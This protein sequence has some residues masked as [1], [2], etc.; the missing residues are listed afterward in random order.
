MK[1][2]FI[3]TVLALLSL[4]TSGQ[5]FFS[6][7]TEYLQ[8]ISVMPADSIIARCDKLIEAAETEDKQSAMAGLIF[9]FFSVSPIMGNESVAIYVADNYFLNHRLK[10]SDPNT[11]PALTTYAE[12]NRESRI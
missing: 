10:W 7:V 3:S 4:C 2:L 12:F 1:R 11:L 8:S 6:G 5:Q 9:D